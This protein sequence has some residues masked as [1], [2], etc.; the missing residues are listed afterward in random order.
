MALNPRI[1]LTSDLH[2]RHKMVAGLRGMTDIDAHDET[3]VTLWNASVAPDDIVWVLGDV[4]LGRAELAWPYVDKLNGRKHLVWGNH[5]AVF[6]GHRDAHRHQEEWRQHFASI[7]AYARRR[8]E[9]REVMLSH[10]P[11]GGDSGPEDRAQQYR[12]RDEGR[13][14][15][16]GHTHSR[17]QVTRSAKG[18]LQVHVGLDAHNLKPVALGWVQKMIREQ[19]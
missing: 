1:W 2:F 8:D 17:E 12:L 6:G 16:H 19:G 14:I 5:D 4:T 18:T 9:G 11:Y 15:I 10:F 13:I 7:Q 3:I